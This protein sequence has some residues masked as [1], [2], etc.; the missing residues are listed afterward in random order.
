MVAPLTASVRVKTSP[1]TLTD[2]VNATVNGYRAKLGNAYCVRSVTLPK[3]YRS[4]TD[5]VNGR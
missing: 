4:I 5:S 3:P 1:K 2:S